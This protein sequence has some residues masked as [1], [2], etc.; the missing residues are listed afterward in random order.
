MPSEPRLYACGAV[1]FDDV[2]PILAPASSSINCLALNPW[3]TS[4]LESLANQQP[5]CSSFSWGWDHVL[6]VDPSGHLRAAGDDSHWQVSAGQAEEDR[7]A[8]RGLQR[9]QLLLLHQLHCPAHDVML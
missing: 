8:D 9:Q 2:R 6:L 5:S 7:W 4:I 3:H 1:G